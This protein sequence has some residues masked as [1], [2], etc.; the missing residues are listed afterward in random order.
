M[1]KGKLA[2]Q[3]SKELQTRGRNETAWKLQR[4]VLIDRDE[5]IRGWDEEERKPIA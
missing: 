3:R 4:A 5:N 1:I 2:T